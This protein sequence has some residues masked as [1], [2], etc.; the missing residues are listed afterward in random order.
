MNK[1]WKKLAAATYPD[2]DVEKAFLDQA[3]VFIQN[4]ATPLMRDPY[5]LGFEI[6]FKNDGNTKMVGIFVFR[7]NQEL[8]YA[9]VFFLNGSVSG[10]DLLYR[11]G[12][13]RF[14][15][16][17]NE[18]CQYILSLESYKEGAPLERDLNEGNK[19]LN[20]QDLIMPSGHMS[21]Y[22]SYKEITDLNEDLP[23]GKDILGEFEKKSEA[24]VKKGSFIK[25]F[26]ME[27]GG[28][29]A[30]DIITKT[31]SENPNFAQALIDN[32]GL[33]NAMPQELNDEIRNTKHTFS[34]L[35][36]KKGFTGKAA[37]HGFEIIDNRK[38]LVKKVYKNEGMKDKSAPVS[39]R[40]MRYFNNVVTLLHEDGT[41]SSHKAASLGNSD[42]SI[43]LFSEDGWDKK[44]MSDLYIIDEE[45]SSE[46]F[47][48]PKTKQLE[49]NSWYTEE[50]FSESGKPAGLREPFLVEEELESLSEGISR[51]RAKTASGDETTIYHNGEREYIPC[52]KR[53]PIN[54]ADDMIFKDLIKA[55][56]M[57]E[58]KVEP[59]GNYFI[60]SSRKG[61][62]PELSKVG[63]VAYLMA[64]LDMDE[65]SSF[66]VMDKAASG[67]VKYYYDPV[68]LEKQA[69]MRMQ[70][71]PEFYA[72][73][74]DTFG[75]PTENP[76]QTTVVADVNNPEAPNP[77]V[78]DR[79]KF[80]GPQGLESHTPE[81][82]TQMAQETG[83]SSLF[84]HGL[85]G[86][87]VNTFD[88]TIM[89]DK[90][91][92]SLEDGLDK[93]GRILFLFYWKPND[94][95]QLYGSDDQASLENKLLS[96]FKSFG[97]LVLELLKKTQNSTKGINLAGHND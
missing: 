93:L 72:G 31:A 13:K 53:S 61:I 59:R 36:F 78:G 20:L 32:V 94:F 18:W 65:K 12:D 81:T 14:V 75:V 84:E 46:D 80:D 22:S 35:A 87:L 85:V 23:T 30:V 79:M 67:R 17:T 91:L 49:I 60:V 7:V 3:Y 57:E 25:D 16:L 42:D 10:T 6:V 64:E 92:V 38:N 41:S 1:D 19:G 24:Q 2:A 27:D 50:S 96:N 89:I 47:E 62:T 90:Y 56:G 29:N 95:S 54:C 37:K 63:S 43:L 45:K 68:V 21:K 70:N 71:I 66:E 88:S 69:T 26:I 73:F 11:H 8:L 83:D 55:A 52:G 76:E 74:D 86:S 51:F 97:D 39:D 34:G 4:K 48:P 77:R 9:P 15:C 44:A 58:V 5:K 82:L 28:Y 33:D 40:Y